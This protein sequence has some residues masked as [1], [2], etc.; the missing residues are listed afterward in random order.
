M[1]IWGMLRGAQ[2]LPGVMAPCGGPHGAGADPVFWGLRFR[3]SD[4]RQHEAF[5]FGF[6]NRVAKFFGGVDPQLNGLMGVS[7]RRFLSVAVR[8][9]AGQFRRLG[10]EY[11]AFVAPVN[12]DLVLVHAY[13]FSL[14]NP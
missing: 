10:N 9:A 13:A 12:D 3:R 5:A 8:D 14:F 2:K 6:G 7:E 4:L 1:G 11:L